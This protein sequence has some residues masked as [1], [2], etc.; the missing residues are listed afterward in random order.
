MKA[1]NNVWSGEGCVHLKCEK[2]SESGVR[3]LHSGLETSA[4]LP[5][6][7][8]TVVPKLAQVS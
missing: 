3:Y 7:A 1:R 6:L 8:N 4:N 5:S 2:A